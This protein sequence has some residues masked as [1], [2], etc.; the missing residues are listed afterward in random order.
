MG[1]YLSSPVKDKE[2][3]EGYDGRFEY[4]VCA[5]QG[6]RTDMVRFWVLCPAREFKACSCDCVVTFT[7]EIT[8]R[9][10]CGCS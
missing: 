10:A 8:G 5:M 2:S 3:G 4:G 1:A 6:W 7:C 9:C